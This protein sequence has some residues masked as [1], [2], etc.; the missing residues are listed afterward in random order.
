LGYAKKSVLAGS[1]FLSRQATLARNDVCLCGE[2]RIE[3]SLV[4]QWI[5]YYLVRIRMETS[6]DSL[7]G[8]QL[9]TVLKVSRVHYRSVP[10]IQ[11]DL[12]FNK[13]GC[14]F[15]FCG[16][17]STILGHVNYTDPG[18]FR[19]HFEFVARRRVRARG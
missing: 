7:S 5:E 18:L 14:L 10:A 1:W 8:E 9:K 2:G 17:G 6:W 11:G 16:R 15:V 19:E 13:V 12:C 3:E 4:R